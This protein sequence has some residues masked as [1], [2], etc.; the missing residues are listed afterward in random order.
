MITNS[1]SE[2]YTSLFSQASEALD[3]PVAISSLQDYYEVLKVLAGKNPVF[4]RI[5]LDEETFDIDLNK[6]KI[7]VPSSFAENGIGVKGDELAEAIYFKSDRYFDSQDLADTDI[8]IEWQVGKTKGISKAF[9]IDKD[10]YQDKIVFGWAITAKMTEGGG[11]ILT[12]APRFIV[13]RTNLDDEQEIVYSLGTKPQ[14]IN[15]NDTLNLIKEKDI[16]VDETDTSTII[17]SIVG[18]DEGITKLYWRRDILK[19]DANFQVDEEY[20]GYLVTVEAMSPLH[21]ISYKWYKRDLDTK[22]STQVQGQWEYTAVYDFNKPFFSPVAQGTPYD[23][24]ETYY[25]RDAETKAYQE[26]AI[27]NFA[28]GVQYYVSNYGPADENH[29][30]R[31]G[32]IDDY[33]FNIYEK[34]ALFCR[35]RKDT[36]EYE[37]ISEELNTLFNGEETNFFV[38]IDDENFINKTKNVYDGKIYRVSCSYLVTKPGQYYATATLNIGEYTK[39]IQSNSFRALKPVSVIDQVQDLSKFNCYIGTPGQDEKYWYF[40]EEK[41]KLYEKSHEDIPSYVFLKVAEMDTVE[42]NPEEGKEI[43]AP[44][45]GIVTYQWE[46]ETIDNEENTVWISINGA[47][48]KQYKVTEPG[49]YRVKVANSLNGEKKEEV[50]STVA[51]IVGLVEMPILDFKENAEDKNITL[52]NTKIELSVTAEEAN[53]DGRYFCW[54]R[55]NPYSLDEAQWKEASDLPLI[56]VDEK[57][58]EKERTGTLIAVLEGTYY[59][60][61]YN[62]LD[63]LIS[64]PVTSGKFIVKKGEA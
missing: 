17:D 62:S 24:T 42:E 47:T 54:Y 13:Q 27:L 44:D 51:K 22:I 12:F 26:V 45:N 23:Q 20:D 40:D 18:G 48:E 50:S 43:I 15:I 1:N 14:T 34:D 57:K 21:Q 55:S 11:N 10:T 37:E 30:N 2:N 59:C 53:C 60:K 5:P 9:C 38:I 25:I 36:G 56:Q 28:S 58:T 33:S 39:T 32:V 29:P 52:E 6:R 3:T 41:K 8:F 49:T 63:G 64:S 35:K 19:H 61:V 4:L 31:Y 46:V 16:V 7:S